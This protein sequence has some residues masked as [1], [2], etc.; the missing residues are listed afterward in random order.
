MLFFNLDWKQILEID[1]IVFQKLDKK[2]QK[3]RFLGQIKNL[4]F[5]RPTIS[6]Q[7]NVSKTL[8]FKSIHRKDYDE[9]FQEICNLIADKLVINIKYKSAGK[10]RL[11]P[12]YLLLKYLPLLISTNLNFNVKIMIYLILC[13]LKYLEIGEKVFKN[14]FER[15]VV[16]ADM[17]AMDNLVSQIAKV[18]KIA[19]I[20]LQHGLYV[21]YEKQ[22]NVNIIN[23]KNHVTDYFLAWGEDTKNLIERYHPSS[24]V[25]ILGKPIIEIKNRE[26]KNYFTVVFDQ[27]I[28]HE[29]NKKILD[30]SYKI[31]ENLNLKINLRLHPNNKLNW[32]NIRKDIVLIDEDLYSS[33]F[34]VGHTTSILYE[35]MR[36]G[37]PSY[38]YRSDIRANMLD[39]EFK[40]T[41]IDELKNKINKH[42]NNNCDFAEYAKRYIKYISDESLEKYKAFFEELEN[43]KY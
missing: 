18:K 15:L 10:I 31:A 38:K 33:K 7:S 11:Y 32:Y 29:Y 42:Q 25:I 27:N 17:Q 23:Y 30:I 35:L 22:F 43:G 41:H 21:D 19:T 6:K 12:F 39:E 9:Q 34:V 28:F 40:F 26:V 8:F 3:R 24:K 36:Q 1:S 4:F 14:K 13:Q 16:F 5:E 20:T 37:I 2:E